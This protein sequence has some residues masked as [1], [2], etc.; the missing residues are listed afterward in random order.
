MTGAEGVE[1]GRG[2]REGQAAV[3]GLW[4]EE[5]SG[6]GQG[7]GSLAGLFGPQRRGP[8]LCISFI[9]YS[10]PRHLPQ[11]L[12]Q[13]PEHLP[14]PPHSKWEVTAPCA[15]SL[16]RHFQETLLIYS[17]ANQTAQT[18]ARDTRKR[19]PRSPW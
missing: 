13:L 4:A 19:L 2:G 18:A 8:A 9:P 6:F 14:S 17:R 12:K 1:G 10:Y 7:G 3:Q 5:A 16:S 15:I 11:G